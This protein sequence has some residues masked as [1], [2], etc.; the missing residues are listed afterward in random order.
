MRCKQCLLLSPAV[1]DLAVGIAATAA[2]KDFLGGQKCFLLDSPTGFGQE[3]SCP[4]RS[5]EAAS[6]GS[7][8]PVAESRKQQSHGNK[9][10]VTNP[11]GSRSATREINPK[12][13]ENV[14][15]C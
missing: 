12:Y 9:A 13:V 15:T 1:L 8:V 7:T 6:S 11:T 2:L 14:F 4:T 3:L 10:A 5:Y